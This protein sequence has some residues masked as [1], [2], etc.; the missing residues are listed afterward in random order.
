VEYITNF[1]VYLPNPEICVLAL[2][3]ED[4]LGVSQNVSP[5]I[6]LITTHF[7]APL[8]CLEFIANSVMKTSSGMLAAVMGS[9]LFSVTSR[10]YDLKNPEKKEYA[11]ASGVR[12]AMEG[13]LPSKSEEDRTFY[14]RYDSYS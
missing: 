10:S 4:F 13:I 12:G 14:I 1:E 3:K 7:Y 8:S 6:E 11:I 5:E 9:R 2:D